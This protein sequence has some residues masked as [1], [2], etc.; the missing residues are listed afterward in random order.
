V[1]DAQLERL[2][3]GVSD[4]RLARALGP[5]LDI[6]VADRLDD[7]LMLRLQQM[8]PGF[9]GAIDLASLVERHFDH[10]HSEVESTWNIRIDMAVESKSSILREQAIRLQ[11]QAT[12][13]VHYRGLE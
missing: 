7:I 4:E 8:A 9:F 10:M 2:M 1:T 6:L 3:D 13:Q 12:H 11:D 5:R